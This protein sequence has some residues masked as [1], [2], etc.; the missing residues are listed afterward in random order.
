MR[1][2]SVHA[3][4]SRPALRRSQRRAGSTVHVSRA[5]HFACSPSLGTVRGEPE[6]RLRP[7]QPGAQAVR[8]H[9]TAAQP[10][11]RP[12][13]PAL[14]LRALLA[15]VHM[16]APLQWAAAA[17]PPCHGARVAFHALLTAQVCLCPVPPKCSLV[18][19]ARCG[20]PVEVSASPRRDALQARHVSL[21]ARARIPRP[22]S[23]AGGARFAL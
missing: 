18:R 3:P 5:E 12:G 11:P 22:A 7:G 20:R 14:A 13:C 21:P 16:P 1:C 17:P 9:A 4:P 2:G 8:A 6:H 23:G 19:C 10:V 15:A